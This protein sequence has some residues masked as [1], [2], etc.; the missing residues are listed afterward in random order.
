M[1]CL[2]V[3]Q[4]TSLTNSIYS[5]D[6]YRLSVCVTEL[7][8]YQQYINAQHRLSVCVIDHES[9]QQFVFK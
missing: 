3:S 2:C 7:Q 8:S 4:N 1:G 6:L 5:N 9:Y